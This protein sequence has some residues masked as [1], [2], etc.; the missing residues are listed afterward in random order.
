MKTSIVIS[1][2][3]TQFE[4]L[5]FKDQLYE[6]IKKVAQLGFDGVEIA[7]RSPEL[8][9]VARLKRILSET[10]LL[11]SAIGT[12]QAYVEE[13][14][15]FSDESATIR[16]LAIERIKSQIDFAAQIGNPIVIIG[17][18]RGTAK[19]TV[20]PDQAWQYVVAAIRECA[21]YGSDKGII[22]AV[23]PMNRYETNLINTMEEGHQLLSEIGNSN[24]GL[25]IDTFHMNIEERSFEQC[26][27]KMAGEIVHVH[28]ADSNRWAPG[29]GHINFRAI[30]DSL[31]NIGYQGYISA[32]ILPKPNPDEAVSLAASY[33][34]KLLNKC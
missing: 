13:Q 6:N 9:D 27:T 3:A 19:G 11:V 21:V 15:S 4:A 1:A 33:M 26:I 2:S 5:A 24:V 32:E 30:I 17:L 25:L 31:M 28:I 12:G 23:E 20:A 16:D 14:L 10:A 7:V 29:C 22:L 8:I 34:R 18:I